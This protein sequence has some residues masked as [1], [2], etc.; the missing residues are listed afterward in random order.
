MYQMAPRIVAAVA[1]SAIAA[2]PTNATATIACS[3]AEA[4]REH[5]APPPG[6]PGRDQV[7][8]DHSLAMTRTR[9]VKMP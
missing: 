5:D 9:G 2:I 3:S 4:E 7:G 1:L 8:R 6:L